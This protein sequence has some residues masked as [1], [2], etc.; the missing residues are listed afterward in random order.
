MS[1]RPDVCAHTWY[2]YVHPLCRVV[3]NVHLLWAVSS[4]V[5]T[6]T[7][8]FS[9]LWA[10]TRYQ[11]GFVLN[12]CLALHGDSLIQIDRCLYGGLKRQITSY[13]LHLYACTS[14]IWIISNLLWEWQGVRPCRLPFFF[15]FLIHFIYPS[16]TSKSTQLLVVSICSEATSLMLL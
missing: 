10:K 2:S 13:I 1:T 15:L 3:K 11:W 16:W 14:G 4:I 7:V 8:V 12:S 6:G 9:P 5:Q